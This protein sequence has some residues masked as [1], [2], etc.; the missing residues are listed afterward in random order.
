MNKQ[1]KYYRCE[2]L[3]EVQNNK[4]LHDYH[5]I[6][7]NLQEKSICNFHIAIRISVV[8][9]ILCDGYPNHY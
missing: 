1:N 5:P 2:L 9:F 7:N 4:K 3:F 8:A 6:Q